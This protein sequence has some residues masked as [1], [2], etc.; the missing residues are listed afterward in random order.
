M[1]KH[2]V[3][4]ASWNIA[5]GPV[6]APL[7]L[8]TSVLKLIQLSLVFKLKLFTM[9]TASIVK[10]LSEDMWCLIILE[11]I[12][13]SFSSYVNKRQKFLICFF[14]MQIIAQFFLF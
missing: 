3:K 14:T 7:F 9:D 4:A 5:S 6:S 1:L 11:F 10:E 12:Q 2:E 8:E 13:I